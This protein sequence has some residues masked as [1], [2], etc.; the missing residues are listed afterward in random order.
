MILF[1]SRELSPN[2]ALYQLTKRG[3]TLIGQ[4]G[5]DFSP[6]SFETFPATDWLFFYSQQGIR[7][8]YAALSSA[9]KVEVLKKKIG[10]MGKASAT[11]IENITGAAPHF[12]AC[13]DLEKEARKFTTLSLNQ[14]VLFIEATHSK[15]R[16]QDPSNPGHFVLQVYDNVVRPDLMLPAADVYIFT[17]PMNVQ[18]FLQS[19]MPEQK[20]GLVAIGQ[21][22]AS[23]LAQFTGRKDIVIADR[24]DE[25]G[26]LTTL[27]KLLNL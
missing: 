23:A 3:H 25:E 6:I 27:S 14:S 17:S 4:S 13:I 15:K 9:Q 21:P 26:I 1:I 5:I 8:F 24:S 19:N 11:L 2:S 7:F 12:T 16:F 18:G 20:A 22:T 10:V